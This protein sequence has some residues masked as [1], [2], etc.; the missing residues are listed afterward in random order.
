MEIKICDVCVFTVN[1]NESFVCGGLD[2]VNLSVI[3]APATMAVVIV[4][5][6]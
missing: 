4:P 3:V 6:Q 1:V 5:I 2:P